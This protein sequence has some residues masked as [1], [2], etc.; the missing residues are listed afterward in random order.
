MVCVVTKWRL[1]WLS[2]IKCMGIMNLEIAWNSSAYIYW[3]PTVG[4]PGGSEV[5]VSSCN[6]GDLGLIPGSG[7]SPGEGMFFPGEFFGQ[8]SLVGCSPWVAKRWTWL[9]DQHSHTVCLCWPV[10]LTTMWSQITS[11][12]LCR[13]LHCFLIS[14]MKVWGCHLLGEDCA[15]CI[16]GEGACE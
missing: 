12:S 7:R 15:F 10:S 4:F 6:A 8:W 14:F 3:S 1:S 2:V 13:A 11:L 16:W 5:K 9:R